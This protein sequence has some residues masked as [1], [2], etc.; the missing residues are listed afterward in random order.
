ML[1]CLINS[2]VLNNTPGDSLVTILKN[3]VFSNI[4]LSRDLRQYF[5]C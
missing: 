5:H 3:E 2:F 4:S 1:T